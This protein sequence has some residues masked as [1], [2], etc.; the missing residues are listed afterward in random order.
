MTA[1]VLALIVHAGICRKAGKHA[2]DILLIL[3]GVIDGQRFRK[4]D[5]HSETPPRLLREKNGH[6]LTR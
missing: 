4:L 1:P 3:G 5:T 2:V 6:R